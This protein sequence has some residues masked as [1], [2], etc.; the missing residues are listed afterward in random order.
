[1][2]LR[3][4]HGFFIDQMSSEKKRY[5]TMF[6]N[7]YFVLTNK[8]AGGEELITAVPCDTEIKMLYSLSY[9]TG[10]AGRVRTDPSIPELNYLKT[11]ISNYKDDAVQIY[12][13]KEAK[14]CYFFVSD[15]RGSVIFYRKRAEMFDTYLARLYV[16]AGNAVKRSTGSNGNSPLAGKLKQI[17]VYQLE[18]D[19]HHKCSIREMNPE[20]DG[21]IMAA[22]KSMVPFKLSLQA[23]EQGGIGYRFTLPD[24]TFTNVFTDANIMQII[25]DLRL[26]M[27]A[28]RGYSF[29][30]TDIDL[31]AVAQSS[32]RNY[33]SF[34]F[35]EK[36]LFEMLVEKGL[37][38]AAR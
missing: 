14:Y 28:T 17:E 24:G 36:N 12:F 37:Q 1:M 21:G 19:I 35:T 5:V 31:S 11:I 3:D 33:T 8:R 26:L 32:Y 13:Q 15:E 18:R 16:F 7:T 10:A 34:A 23:P 4:A 9:N 22:K 38:A 30:V 2:T 20:L 6:G 25:G 27:R 29:Y